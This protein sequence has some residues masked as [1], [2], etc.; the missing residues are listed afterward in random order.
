MV[1]MMLLSDKVRA[2][3]TPYYYGYLNEY[4]AIAVKAFDE[5]DGVCWTP[6]EDNSIGDAWKGIG[7]NSASSR[8]R[9]NFYRETD[10]N[11]WNHYTVRRCDDMGDPKS[12]GNVWGHCGVHYI[13]HEANNT[14]CLA[15]TDG[16]GTV[17]VDSDGAPLGICDCSRRLRGSGDPRAIWPLALRRTPI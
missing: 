1:Y 5:S 13:Y 7:C 3:C 16:N 14:L 10:S 15:A 6:H 4:S 17:L 8:C 2:D 11:I 9:I 12:C